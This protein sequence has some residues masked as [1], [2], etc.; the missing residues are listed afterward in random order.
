MKVITKIVRFSN[1]LIDG[2][3]AAIIILMLL[4]SIWGLRDTLGVISDSTLDS[5]IMDLKPSEPD[6]YKQMEE[7]TGYNQSLVVLS[8]RYPDVVSWLEVYD[9]NIDYPVVQGKDNEE[10]VYKSIDGKDTKSGTIFL[11]SRND[12]LYIDTYSLLYGHHIIGGLMFTDIV[13]FGDEEYFNEH[14]WGKLWLTDATY[15]IEIFSIIKCDALDEAYF[16]PTLYTNTDTTEFINMIK[17]DA[18]NWRD[19]EVDSDDKVIGF[20][21]CIDA[22]TNERVILFGI[23]KNTV[24][25]EKTS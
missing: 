21:T 3:F 8:E 16:N 7:T 20:S 19:V 13:L 24:F 17:E 23:L 9:T 15:D 14:E 1:S 12:K 22:Y 18:I 4:F 6:D 2:C 5:D 11:D 10:Y 25:E